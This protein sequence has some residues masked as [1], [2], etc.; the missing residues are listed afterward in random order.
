MGLV[1]IQIIYDCVQLGLYFLRRFFITHSNVS[2]YWDS[3]TPRLRD[4]NLE[5]KK[6][7]LVM[8]VCVCMMKL[9]MCWENIDQSTVTI[10]SQRNRVFPCTQGYFLWCRVGIAINLSVYDSCMQLM[11]IICT[12]AM[13]CYCLI[14]SQKMCQ[15]LVVI[16]KTIQ[17]IFPCNKMV[18]SNIIPRNVSVSEWYIQMWSQ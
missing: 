7:P 6:E 10:K 15:Y 11:Q 9:E 13:Q 5:M 16:F 17:I 1:L 14:L 12:L 18:S 3:Q 8:H 4:K 2:N